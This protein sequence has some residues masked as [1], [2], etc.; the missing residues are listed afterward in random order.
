M[1][2]LIKISAN[3]PTVDIDGTTYITNQAT[4]GKWYVYAVDASTSTD[5]DAMVTVW[6]MVPNVPLVLGVHTGHGA[7]KG[8]SLGTR[9]YSKHH[10]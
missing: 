1:L 3:G 8:N 10:R 4:N 2:Q 7:E 5:L 9:G 6:S